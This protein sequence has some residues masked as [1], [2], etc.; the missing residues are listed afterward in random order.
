LFFAGITQKLYSQTTG[1]LT[2][3]VN[4][5]SHNAGYGLE[6]VSAI[7]IEDASTGFVKTKYRRASGHTLNNHLPIWKAKSGSNVVDATTGATLTT[8]SPITVT[9]NATNVSAA[10]VTD[11]VYRV[12]VEFTW[13]D[14]SSN[15]DTTSVNFTKGVNA[16]HLTPANKTNFTGMVLDW[17]PTFVGVK[18]NAPEN[19]YTIYPN[20]STGL[21]HIEMKESTGEGLVKVVDASGAIVYAKDF[22]SGTGAS[23]TIDLSNLRNGIYYITVQKDSQ[24]RGFKQ[25]LVINK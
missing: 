20:P 15:H 10:V 8:Y 23:K 2:F 9:W 21:V 24:S 14:G 1:T 13:D 17:V 3:T 18:E 6:H 7:W 5:T 11:G 12:K 4:L 16:V 22:A 25:K 19:N